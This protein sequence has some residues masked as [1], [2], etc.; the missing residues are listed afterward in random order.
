MKIIQSGNTYDLYDNSVKTFDALPPKVYTL[1]HHPQRGCYLADHAAITVSEKVYGVQKQKTDKVMRSFALFTRSLGVILSG[2]KGSGKTMF[3]KKLC[4]RAIEEGLPVILVEKNL[5]GLARFLERIEQ[6]CVVLFDEFEKTFRN[7]EANENDDDYDESETESHEQEKLLGLFDGTSGGKKL[8]VI[9]CNEVEELNNCL[10]NR[11]GRFHYHFRFDYPSECEI[12]EYLKDHLDTL[13]HPAIPAVIS[14]SKRVKLNYDC[15]RAI[16][17]ELNTGASFSEIISDLNI[18]N[19]EEYAYDVTL[20]FE[21][22]K[23]LIEKRYKADL[24]DEENPFG[25]IDL[26]DGSGHQIAEVSFNKAKFIYEESDGTS[27]IPPDGFTV[28][29]TAY[30]DDDQRK[31]AAYQKSKPVRLIFSRSRTT[32]LH[33]LV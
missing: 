17:F 7:R 25:W 13:Y 3:A 6:E 11:P 26:H 1:E 31:T 20:C 5:P 28:N 23:R 15:L 9:T 8:F 24:Y 18:L 22:G 14:F 10:I 19:I 12:D 16:A 27:Y 29:Y 33:Y 32:N 30:D 4:E 21:N 2:D